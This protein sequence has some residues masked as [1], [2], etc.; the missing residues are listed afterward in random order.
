MNQQQKVIK[1]NVNHISTDL[2]K[3]KKRLYITSG[4]DDNEPVDKFRCPNHYKLPWEQS[5]DVFITMIWAH[6]K[7]P[8]RNLENINTRHV[9]DKTR[10]DRNT[11]TDSTARW[12][13]NWWKKASGCKCKS[14]SR[15]LS[16]STTLFSDQGTINLSISVSAQQTHPCGYWLGHKETSH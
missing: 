1:L 13:E 4:V 15:Y 14:Q 2:T 12:G 3:T 11:E 10:G 7:I 6:E 8:G 5:E 16:L 9:R